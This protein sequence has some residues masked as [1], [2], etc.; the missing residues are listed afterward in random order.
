MP[1]TDPRKNAAKGS[2]LDWFKG[3]R[4]DNLCGVFPDVAKKPQGFEDKMVWLK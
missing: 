1:M 3:V 4:G 2:F